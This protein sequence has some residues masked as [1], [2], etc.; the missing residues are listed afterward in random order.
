LNEIHHPQAGKIAKATV[1][2]AAV[3]RDGT[4]AWEGTGFVVSDSA[5]GGTQGIADRDRSPCD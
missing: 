2:I 3:A 4:L 1:F 5:D